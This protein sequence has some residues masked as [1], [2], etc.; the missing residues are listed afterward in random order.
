MCPTCEQGTAHLDTHEAYT[1][2]LET[3]IAEE[4]EYFTG[5]TI[6]EEDLKDG[7][8]TLGPVEERPSTFYKT[9]E[10]AL[11]HRNNVDNWKEAVYDKDFVDRGYLEHWMTSPLVNN[12]RIIRIIK[13]K[14]R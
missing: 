2:D 3:K 12:E 4:K 5:L 13:Q 11:T 10:E 14:Q 6:K 7:I 9:L 1:K 8:E